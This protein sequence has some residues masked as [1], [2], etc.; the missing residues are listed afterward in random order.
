MGLISRVSSR[1][2][3]DLSSPPKML[4]R[5]HLAKRLIS[6]G[7]IAPASNPDLSESTLSKL[8]VA[9]ENL[10][11]GQ[12]RSLY[13]E[14]DTHEVLNLVNLEEEAPKKKKYDERNENNEF[15]R[16]AIGNAVKSFK[17]S[18]LDQVDFSSGF[19]ADSHF[20]VAEAATLATHSYKEK[21]RA[22]FPKLDF[23][24]LDSAAATKGKIY[25]QAQNLA[26]DLMETPANLMTPEIFAKTIQEKVAEW[27]LENVEVV[28]RDK[29]WIR[30]M[31]MESFWSVSQGSAVPPVLLEVHVNRPKGELEGDEDELGLRTSK[32][33]LCF[34]GKGVTFDSG[35]ISIKPSANMDLMRAD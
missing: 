14:V 32:P 10:K 9:G 20:Y 29:A 12:N 21:E 18:K 35:G 23:A 33:E 1:T 24:D 28:V 11:S 31:K 13:H 19:P 17:G 6:K 25:A 5:L 4:Q 26:R 16:T 30:A 7:L 15:I 34:V 8:K 3:R 2:Y 22:K 27:D